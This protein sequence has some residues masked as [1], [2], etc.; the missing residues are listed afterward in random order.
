M[1]PLFSQQRASPIS[2]LYILELYIV[3]T[4]KSYFPVEIGA[5]TDE[6]Y[7]DKLLLLLSEV[8]KN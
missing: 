3:Q 4:L 7:A 2:H 1:S 5:V 8:T 6:Y